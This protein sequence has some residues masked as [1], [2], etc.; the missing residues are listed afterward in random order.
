MKLCTICPSCKLYKSYVKEM[1]NSGFSCCLLLCSLGP[2]GLRLPKISVG[3]VPLLYETMFKDY[4]VRKSCSL[5]INGSI[6]VGF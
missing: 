5:W 4:L 1:T 3:E 2:E 6:K